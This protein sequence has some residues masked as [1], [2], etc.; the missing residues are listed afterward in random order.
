MSS[1]FGLLNKIDSFCVSRVKTIVVF[2]NGYHWFLVTGG[3]V[4]GEVGLDFSFSSGIT[5]LPRAA[6]SPLSRGCRLCKDSGRLERDLIPTNSKSPGLYVA[7]ATCPF[8][9]DTKIRC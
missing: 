2:V 6:V 8:S 9:A 1:P 7:R 4:W 3:R 5:F